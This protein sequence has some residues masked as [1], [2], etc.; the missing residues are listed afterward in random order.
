MRQYELMVI[1]DPE[2]DERT[3]A[4]SLD[5]F[6]NVVT[7]D[8]GTVDNVD[9]W[10]R[11]RLAYEIKKKSEGIYAVVNLTAEPATAKELDRQLGPQR[12]GPA[13]QAPA[14][15]RLSSHVRPDTDD[16]RRGARHGWRHRHHRHRQPH[17]RPG[18]AV[19]PVRRRRRELHRRVHAAQFDRQSNEWKDGE[20]L[21][22][23]C[24]VWRDAAENVA[25]SLAARHPRDRVRPPEV[26]APTRPRKARSAPS[27]RWRS[28]RSARRCA[29]PRPRSPRPSAAVAV[30]AASAAASGGSGGGGWAAASRAAQ[31][32]RTRGPPGRQRAARPGGQGGG[33]QGGWGNTPATTS[34]PS[35]PAT[36]TGAQLRPPHRCGRRSLR[37][38]IRRRTGGAGAAAHRSPLLDQK[39][40]SSYDGVSPQP[41]CWPPP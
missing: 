21:F 27:S 2:L 25:E 8:G 5:K 40:G 9:I 30:A 18:A 38:R 35:D 6:L 37:R 11:R 33:Q 24:S 15:R 23:R 4:P 41:P 14:P 13:D 1:L 36:G 28:T 16:R 32:E 3:V 29:M 12:V 39:G 10:G 17:R 26:R 22:M 19:H 34:P 7:K 31:A 20:T